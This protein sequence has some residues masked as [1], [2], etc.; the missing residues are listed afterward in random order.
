MPLSQ[1]KQQLGPS[2]AGRCRRD[3]PADPVA[4]DFR[5]LDLGDGKC[6]SCEISQLCPSDQETKVAMIITLGIAGGIIR[7]AD[8]L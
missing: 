6:W 7:D 4:S 2:E 1:P 8:Y 3:N 5:P